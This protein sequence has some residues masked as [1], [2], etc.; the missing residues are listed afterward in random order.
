M[1]SIVSFFAGAA[2]LTLVGYVCLTASRLD[3][4]LAEAQ[5]RFATENYDGSD[6]TFDRAE[7]YYGYASRLPGV[8]NGPLNDVQVRRAAA[9]YWQRDYDAFLPQETEAVAAIAPDNIDLQLLVA[10]AVY[11]S[12]L[13]TAT[14]RE[15]RLLAIDTGI[16]AYLTVLRNAPRNESA[17]FN[18][19][20]LVK[21]RDEVDGDDKE[22]GGDEGEDNPNGKG[23]APSPEQGNA[24][25]F[26]IYIPL[27]SN[28]ML[29]GGGAAGK[30][31]P[32]ERKG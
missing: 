13:R 31:T 14:D 30:A 23:G 19:E 10:N 21:L 9:H 22:P 15:T 3:R 4:D 5:Q 26:K 2:I 8:G 7:R 32:T 12:G 20:Y 29:E 27:E 28:E 18:Y 1:K 24:D 11:R 16:N 25:Q 17:A 6:E